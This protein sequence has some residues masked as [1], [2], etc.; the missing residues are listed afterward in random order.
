MPK[1][2][3]TRIEEKTALAIFPF[4]FAPIMREIKTSLPRESPLRPQVKKTISG[5][6]EPTAAS[7]LSETKLP[8]TRVSAKLKEICKMFATM[9]GQAKTRIFFINSTFSL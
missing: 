8:T 1:N 9:I 2:K 4:S 7:P 3:A 5:A 6:A